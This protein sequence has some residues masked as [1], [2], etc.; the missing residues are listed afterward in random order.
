[1]RNGYGASTSQIATNFLYCGADVAN[2][3][4]TIAVGNRINETNKTQSKTITLTTDANGVTA[5]SEQVSTS[6][7]QATTATFNALNELTQ[8]NEPNGISNFTYDLNGNLKEIRKNSTIIS[9]YEHDITNQLTKAKDG[10]DNELARFDYDFER[11]RTVKTNSLGNVVL[12]ESL[13]IDGSG[14][15]LESQNT[16][17]NVGDTKQ[18]A[19]GSFKYSIQTDYGRFEKSLPQMFTLDFQPKGGKSAKYQQRIK[20]ISE[21]LRQLPAGMHIVPV[22]LYGNN[23]DIAVGAFFIDIGGGRFQFCLRRHSHHRNN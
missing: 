22:R 13:E 23:G 5:R 3:V 4:K 2:G 17:V 21:Q 12:K 16:I 9:K 7:E 20:L 18:C 6:P 15:Y 14:L 1:M 8:L 19:N 11:K 10:L